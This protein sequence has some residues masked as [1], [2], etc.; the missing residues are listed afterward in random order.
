MSIV[1]S[2]SRHTLVT[3]SRAAYSRHIAG[4]PGM[5]RS[6]Y[7]VV[8][9]ILLTIPSVT[10]LA[11]SS[12]VNVPVEG[13]ID[14]TILKHTDW[15][16]HWLFANWEARAL[17]GY[18]I[19][20]NQAGVRKPVVLSQK[21]QPSPRSIHHIQ[22][23]CID[24][25]TTNRIQIA[26]ERENEV[27]QIG[28]YFLACDSRTEQ[29]QFT[30]ASRY[31]YEGFPIYKQH[32]R[33]VGSCV[34]RV[35][36]SHEDSRQRGVVIHSGETVCMNYQST[37]PGRYLSAYMESSPNTGQSSHDTP[38]TSAAYIS[39]TELG[40]SNT[41]LQ[42]NSAVVLLKVKASYFTTYRACAKQFPG[43]V[44][45]ILRIISVL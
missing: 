33:K 2:I 27:V 22:F 6:T 45:A 24:N 42:H 4:C 12:D 7:H 39:L 43:K 26:V 10:P 41:V 19:K 11:R 30:E 40:T 37:D 5:L 18:G 38:V 36:S 32:F 34:P 31:D 23:S 17:E 44:T 29:P 35:P 3:Q 25:R 9:R 16:C 8:V 13:V 1:P 15:V 28:P 21:A 20:T 14:A